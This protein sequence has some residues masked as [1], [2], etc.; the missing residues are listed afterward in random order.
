MI[1]DRKVEEKPELL[2]KK[3]TELLEDD[4]KRQELARKLHEISKP[5]AA[6]LMMEMIVEARTRKQK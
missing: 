4:K 3:I 2:L 1:L 6:T 5:D